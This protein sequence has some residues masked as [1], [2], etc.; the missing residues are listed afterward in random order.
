[1]ATSPLPYAEA[2]TRSVDQAYLEGSYSAS[3]SDASTCWWLL[4][5]GGA[6]DAIDIRVCGAPS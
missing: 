4:D 2:T 3:L 1:V 5:I 6:A